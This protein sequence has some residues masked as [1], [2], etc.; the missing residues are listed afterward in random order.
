LIE[1]S[2]T[3]VRQRVAQGRSIRYWVP[4]PVRQYILANGLYR[5]SVSPQS[6]FLLY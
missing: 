6:V 4:E 2:G 1:I 3:T 5:P